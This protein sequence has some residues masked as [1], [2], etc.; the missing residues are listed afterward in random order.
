ML[1]VLS[2]A[3][4]VAQT[5]ARDRTTPLPVT[6]TA[7]IRGR[8]FV[9]ATNDAVRHAVLTISGGGTRVPA[10]LSDEEGRFQFTALPPAT[11]TIVAAKPG[12]AKTSVTLEVGAG[13]TVEAPPIALPRGSVLTGSMI[14]EVGEPVVDSGVLLLRVNPKDDGTAQQVVVGSVYTDDL[15]AFRFGSLAAGTYAVNHNASGQRRHPERAARHRSRP[16]C[17][18]ISDSRL[19]ALLASSRRRT[20]GDC[21]H[22]LRRSAA[23]ATAASTFAS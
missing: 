15:G 16:S 10:I 5:P 17:H 13:R 8:V 19:G 23:D 22:R 9:S 3:T 4:L 7:A 12:F 18:P 14:D 6:G 1:F 21:D 11:F 2:S 20:F